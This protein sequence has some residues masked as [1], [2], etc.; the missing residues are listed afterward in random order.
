M[1]SYWPAALGSLIVLLTLREVFRDLFNPSATGSLSDFVARNVFNLFRHIPRLLS[2]AGPLSIVLVIFIWA[3]SVCVGFALIYWAM[4]TGH[5]KVQVGQPPVGFW[6]MV[7]FS[8]NIVTTLGLGDYGPVP[9]WLHLLVTF[10]AL[11]GFG[12]LTASISSIVLVQAAVGRTRNLARRISLLNRAEQEMGSS[13]N[14]ENAERALTDFSAGLVQARV[15]LVLYPIVYYFY[16]DKTQASLPAALPYA[17]RVAN[18]GMS[19]Q[20]SERT[21]L[22]AQLLRLALGDLAAI[23]RGRFVDS[24]TEDCEAVFQSYARHHLSPS[25]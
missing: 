2:S 19:E 12:I 13:I 14:G 24:P 20:N 11:L 18:A 1:W 22:S 4:P 16:T 15:D 10:E 9:V 25:V 3:M 17:L 6:P 8:L 7:Y 5:F 23:L 21:R